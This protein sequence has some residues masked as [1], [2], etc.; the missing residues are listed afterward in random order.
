MRTR[1][2]VPNTQRPQ[3]SPHYRK[4]QMLRKHSKL[5]YLLVAATVLAS[6]LGE[7]G[8]HW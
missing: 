4:A 5:V 6:F 1:A 8:W 7:L 2:L 3:A